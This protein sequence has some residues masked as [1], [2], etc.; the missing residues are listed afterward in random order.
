MSKILVWVQNTNVLHACP[1]VVCKI[2][3]VIQK[4][5]V[6]IVF[7][8]KMSQHLYRFE[9]FLQRAEEQLLSLRN[10]GKR[11]RRDAQP[12]PLARAGRARRTAAERRPTATG[13]GTSSAPLP[14]EDWDRPFAGLHYA[15]LTTSFT[16]H[17]SGKRMPTSSTRRFPRCFAGSLLARF[18]PL[19]DGSPARGFGIARKMASRDPSGQGPAHASVGHQ[20]G[21]L[22]PTLVHWCARQSRRLT[23]APWCL[24]LERGRQQCRARTACP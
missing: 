24:P 15:V 20:L 9:D 14:G 22:T 11:K 23:P 2:E 17:S 16:R 10:A 3:E 12:D 1:N 13:A 21:A 8:G 7:D 5:R 6:D 4:R 18:P 19:R